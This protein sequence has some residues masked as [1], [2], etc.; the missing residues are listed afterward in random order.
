MFTNLCTQIQSKKEMKISKIRSDHE[1]E[2]ENDPF[3]MFC[4]KH[5]IIHEFSPPRTLQQNGVAERKN[6]FL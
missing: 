3:E 1:G 4:T 5:G 2:F 6:I